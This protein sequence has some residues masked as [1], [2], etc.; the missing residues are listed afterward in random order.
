MSAAPSESVLGATQ[1]HTAKGSWKNLGTTTYNTAFGAVSTVA[2]VLCTYPKTG[3][4]T[5]TVPATDTALGKFVYP[6]GDDSLEGQVVDILFYG[7][8]TTNQ[9]FSAQ[10]WL[11]HSIR[12]DSASD[13]NKTVIEQWF[14]LC[15]YTTM[16]ITLSARAGI[17]GG[18]IDASSLYADTI[19]SPV[20]DRSGN[21]LG[22]QTTQ[23][24]GA[25]D[26]A[27]A[28][29]NNID[30]GRA[31][32]IMILVTRNGGTAASIGVCCTGKAG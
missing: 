14:P 19:G 18:I 11:W 21:P 10:V 28:T 17:A 12:Q 29:L 24:A 22:F 16:T 27:I 6:G 26:D 2:D 25:P 5:G 15:L 13:P 32:K 30:V 7:T 8:T 1:Q 4:R 3:D 23:A 20:V 9:T 31:K